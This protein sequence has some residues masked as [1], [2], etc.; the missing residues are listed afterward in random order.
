MKPVVKLF[1]G[2]FEGSGGNLIRTFSKI[3][4]KDKLLSSGVNVYRRRVEKVIPKT[5]SKLHSHK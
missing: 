3:E 4:G 5:A 2:F 1:F